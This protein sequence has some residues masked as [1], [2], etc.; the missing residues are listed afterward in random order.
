MVA[1]QEA[2]VKFRLTR[3]RPPNPYRGSAFG[4]CLVTLIGYRAAVRLCMPVRSLEDFIW[5]LVDATVVAFI[6]LFAH[7][8]RS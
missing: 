5:H 8:D 7:G 4:M 1:R 2:R 6:L 3:K